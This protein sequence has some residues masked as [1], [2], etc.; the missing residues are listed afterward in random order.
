MTTAESVLCRAKFVVFRHEFG[1]LAMYKA[2]H[3]LN[4]KTGEAHWSVVVGK[5]FR[6]LLEHW[7]NVGSYP[8]SGELTGF[9]RTVKEFS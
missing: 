7:G 4:S 2:F 6:S 5:M 9:H 3:N 8:V 1:Q